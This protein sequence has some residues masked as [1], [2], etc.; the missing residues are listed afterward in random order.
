MR[1]VA[2][3]S[4]IAVCGLAL[5]V[6]SCGLVPRSTELTLP[7]GT[8]AD[9]EGQFGTLLVEGRFIEFNGR[10]FTRPSNGE[11]GSNVDSGKYEYMVRED[12]SVRLYGSSNSTYFLELACCWTWNGKSFEFLPDHNR[13]ERTIFARVTRE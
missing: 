10:F 3:R 8:Y 7:A 1:G 6:A 4:S 13:L 5:L 11:S 9:A 12:G 2:M